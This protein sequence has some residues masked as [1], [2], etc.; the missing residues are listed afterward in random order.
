MGRLH[1]HRARPSRRQESRW[2]P[3]CQRFTA[4]VANP[5]Y[6]SDD[7]VAQQRL[8][9]VFAGLDTGPGAGDELHQPDRGRSGIAGIAGNIYAEAVVGG[10]F[11]GDPQL[12]G[13]FGPRH[14]GL[15]IAS[16]AANRFEPAVDH[17]LRRIDA[18]R[19]SDLQI[20][21]ALARGYGVVVSSSDLTLLRDAA[22]GEVEALGAKRG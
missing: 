3:N 2:H 20:V 10:E 18:A 9:H 14:G 13:G 12:M 19:V 21:I 5:R 7:I 8:A 17:H 15:D 22:R 4:P 6:G 16:L 1:H 11:R